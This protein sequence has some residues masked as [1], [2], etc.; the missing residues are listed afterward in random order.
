MLQYS[1][2]VQ[3]ERRRK[4]LKKWLLGN[5]L[6]IPYLFLWLAGIIFFDKL[7][8][9]LAIFEN[10]PDM[11]LVNIIVNFLIIVF[12]LFFW[13][14]FIVLFFGILLLLFQD[15]NTN[16]LEDEE[17]DSFSRGISPKAVNRIV[18][19][20][21]KV[22]P[23]RTEIH[24]SFVDIQI[25]IDTAWSITDLFRKFLTSYINI[26]KKLYEIDGIDRIA[27]FME[28]VF[29]KESGE[30][31]VKGSLLIDFGKDAFYQSNL[32]S[33]YNPWKTLDVVKESGGDM[34][35]AYSYLLQIQEEKEK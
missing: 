9:F 26:S 29:V 24:G 14:L 23:I 12:V 13:P 21:G 10:L 15:R 33:D 17:S 22:I 5:L 31:V 3:F 16:E 19:E 4:A 28:D 35:I 11:V 8:R 25:D 20:E 18:S 1:K 7:F 27:I 2:D 30:K 6:Y 34:G 32:K